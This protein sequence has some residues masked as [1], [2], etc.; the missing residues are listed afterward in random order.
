MININ[1]ILKKQKRELKTTQWTMK[2][3]IIKSTKKSKWNN[4]IY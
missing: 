2:A 1:D 3:V 4:Q